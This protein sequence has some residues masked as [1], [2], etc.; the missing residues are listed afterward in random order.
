MAKQIKQKPSK[1]AVAKTASKKTSAKSSPVAKKAL[2]K[3]VKQKPMISKTSEKSQPLSKEQRIKHALKKLTGNKNT[4]MVFK[5]PSK[6]NTPVSF[7][8]HEVRDLIKERSQKPVAEKLD[9]NPAA[10]KKAALAAAMEVEQK[11]RVLKS[12]TLDDLLGGGKKKVTAL[13]Y[14]EKSVE[15]RFLPYFKKLIAM[16]ERITQSVGERSEQTLKS[17]AKEASGDLSGYGGSMADA[18]TDAFDY[19][20]ALSLVSGEQDMIREIDAALARIMAG[21]YGVCE[22]TH[23]PISRDRL[24]AVPFARFSKEGQDQHEKTRRRTTQRIGISSSEDEDQQ[25]SG[26]DDGEA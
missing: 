1:P 22:V 25:A 8:L 7:S 11:P 20:F 9:V 17:S 10:K 19:D 24:N 13:E 14:D 26:E 12:A 4:P 2:S 6:K 5:L 3:T 15:S 23:K 21:T 18:G 16:R